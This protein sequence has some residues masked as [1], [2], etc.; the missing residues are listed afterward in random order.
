M[1][2]DEITRVW[3]G[4][5]VKW[6]Q[7][8]DGLMVHGVAASP[9]LDLDAQVCDPAWLKASMP[10]WMRWGNVRE[11]HST[12]A[13]G[14]GK[15]LEADGDKWSL[16]AL[17][18]DQSTAA[19]VKAGVLKGYSVGIKGAQVV[20]DA[21]ARNGRIVGGKIVEISLVDRPCNPEATLALAK[22]EGGMLAPVDQAGVV[23]HTIDDVAKVETVTEPAGQAPKVRSAK[24][25]TPSQHRKALAVMA[26]VNSG[27][28]LKY[29]EAS[30]ISAAQSILSSIADLIISEATE[31]KNGRPEE[32]YD[33]QTLMQAC[34][35]MRSFLRSEQDQAE[36]AP[37]SDG[38]DVSGGISYAMMAAT[39]ETAKAPAIPAQRAS[40]DDVDKAA[41]PMTMPDGSYPISDQHSLDSAAGLAG[42]SKTYGK[43]EVQ[44]H[45]RS[46]AEALGLSLPDSYSKAKGAKTKA[47]AADVDKAA[48]PG[49]TDLAELIK[50]AVAEATSG[51]EATLKALQ[52][53]LAKVKATPIPGGPVLASATRPSN[54]LNPE[55]T[56]IARLRKSATT[57]TDPVTARAYAELADRKEAALK[58]A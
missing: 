1:T 29:D 19:K 3:A 52:A 6:D 8:P 5:L 16:D 18:V 47:A 2:T 26:K 41:K 57:I 20:K 44:A 9:A 30:D 11:Q 48:G 23:L 13:A 39:P 33:I 35:A 24:I 50:S 17:V 58:G 49:D 22:A 31:L 43:A 45:V 25:L 27:E 34:Q 42:K 7:T 56:E 40:E 10:D 53:E 38:S 32:Y 37:A 15:T 54:A 51:Q 55:L 28:I 46:A 21:V 36:T 4:D 12:I 14:V